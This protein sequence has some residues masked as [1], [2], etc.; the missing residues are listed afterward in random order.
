MKAVMLRDMRTRFFNHGLGFLVVSLWPLAHMLILLLIY[1]IA[2]RQTPFGNSL[3]V[4][5]ATGLIPTLAFMYISRFMSLSLILN[6]PMLL[7]PA[8][9]VVDIMTARAFLEIIA[10]FITVVFMFLILWAMGDDPIPFSKEQAVYAFLATMLLSVGIGSLAGVIVM[11]FPFFCYYLRAGN[12]NS[13]SCFWYT[14][15]RICI[16]G[17]DCNSVVLQSC[18]ARGRVDAY[19]LTIRLTATRSSTKNTSSVSDWCH[20]S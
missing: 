1:T 11:F 9:T 10:A 8:V 13:L 5:F 3:N 16:A 12:D 2:G 19:W 17:C 18:R 7:F 14:I 6:R 15:C 4:F 20:F